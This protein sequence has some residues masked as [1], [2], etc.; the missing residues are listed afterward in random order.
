MF[1]LD[2]KHML[3]SDDIFVKKVKSNHF[4]GPLRNHSSFPFW[5]KKRS[6]GIKSGF[7]YNLT[8][9]PLLKS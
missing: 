4:W 2:F 8:T 1:L 7:I 9:A 6:E 5:G 3:F